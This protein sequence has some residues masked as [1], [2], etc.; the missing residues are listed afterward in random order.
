MLDQVLDYVNDGVSKHLGQIADS[1]HE[2]KGPVAEELGLT[3]VD[4][5]AITT[6]YPSEL[7][8]QT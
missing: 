5:A 6:K 8:L 2:W 3:I 4:I 1:M 7:I